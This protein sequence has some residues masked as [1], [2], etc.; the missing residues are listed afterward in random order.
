VVGLEKCYPFSIIPYGLAVVK[1]FYQATQQKKRAS[2][3]I[4]HVFRGF[5]HQDLLARSQAL[6]QSHHVVSVSM[7]DNSEGL[8]LL[9]SVTRDILAEKDSTAICY[10]SS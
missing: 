3:D 10:G 4:D 5:R 9:K 8:G 6:P 1:G 7:S 2:H